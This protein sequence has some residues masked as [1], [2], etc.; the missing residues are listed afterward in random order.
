MSNVMP[1]AAKSEPPAGP[2]HGR[3]VRAVT[4]R[5]PAAM[6]APFSIS[7]VPGLYSKSDSVSFSCTVYVNCS[8]LVVSL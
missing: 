5:G 2:V 3:A 6:V 1:C 4:F 7:A 8:V